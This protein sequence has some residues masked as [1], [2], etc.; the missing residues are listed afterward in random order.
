MTSRCSAGVSEYISP[1]PP[2]ATTAQIGCASSFAKFSWRPSTSRD[3][4]LLNG[5]IGKAIT[6]ESLPRSS[7]GSIMLCPT[8]FSLSFLSEENSQQRIRQAE[9]CRTLHLAQT[10]YIPRPQALSVAQPTALKHKAE[11]RP[12]ARCPPTRLLHAEPSPAPIG[13]ADPQAK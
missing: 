2:A 8:N 13:R 10:D 7:L 5:V 3:K 6:P 1:V 11:S 12:S 4:S 9:A